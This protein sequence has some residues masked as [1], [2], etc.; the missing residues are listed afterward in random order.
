M[1]DV[2]GGWVG[3]LAGLTVMV[4]SG[5]TTHVLCVSCT[6]SCCLCIVAAVY[7]AGAF[8]EQLAPAAKCDAAGT[9]HASLF[10]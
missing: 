6:R 8:A 2:L 7:T 9:L 5:R 3:G 1:A 4:A 10:H